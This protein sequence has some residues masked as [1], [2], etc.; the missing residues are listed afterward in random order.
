MER[1]VGPFPPRR[2]VELLNGIRSALGL[3]LGRSATLEDLERMTGRPG[4]TI[5]DWCEGNPTPQI[6]ALLCMLERVPLDARHALF[7]RACRVHPSLYSQV[8]AHD[9]HAIDGLNEILQKPVGLTW[10]IGDPE[11]MRTYVLMALANGYVRL[12]R[13]MQFLAGLDI[14][15]QDQFVPLPNVIYLN[16]PFATC[17][18][19]AL[20]LER[21][22]SILSAAASC[23][24]LNGAV[25]AAP[26]I[27]AQALA[28]SAKCHVIIADELSGAAKETATLRNQARHLIKVSA[29]RHQ[30]AWIHLQIKEL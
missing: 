18:T 30:P 16:Q 15:A 13:G 1:G 3:D 10:I 7:D 5:S 14:H 19:Q 9:Y 25:G 26:Q 4:K 11:F 29:H 21:W 20:V 17:R 23:V 27:A 28:F 8:L 2:I 22:P 24:V 6:A 12:N